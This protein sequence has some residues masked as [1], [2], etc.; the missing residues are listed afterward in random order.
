M[1]GSPP[2]PESSLEVPQGDLSRL[3]ATN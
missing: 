2:S 1:S 3:C